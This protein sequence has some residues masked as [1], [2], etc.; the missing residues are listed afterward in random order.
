MPDDVAQSLRET[1][2][3]TKDFTQGVLNVCIC[4]DAKEEIDQALEQTEEAYSRD[5]DLDCVKHFE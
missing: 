1:E 4:Y 2:E 5:T 3:M